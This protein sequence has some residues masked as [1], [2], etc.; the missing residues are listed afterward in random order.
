MRSLTWKWKARSSRRRLSR[1]HRLVA[2]TLYTSWTRRYGLE[3]TSSLLDWT[4]GLT[5]DLS[6]VLAQKPNEVST[7]SVE[8]PLPLLSH[9]LGMSN[10]QVA[11]LLTDLQIAL[12]HRYRSIRTAPY[13]EL[14]ITSKP[15]RPSP[16]KAVAAT[17]RHSR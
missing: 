3:P 7:R 8:I 9:Q 12:D 15:A 11:E 13:F 5:A 17:A 2:G 14:L 4:S 16:L 6:W 10:T 1:L